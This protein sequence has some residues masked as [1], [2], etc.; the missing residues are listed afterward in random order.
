MWA[1][2]LSV[3]FSMEIRGRI[4]LKTFLLYGNTWPDT[5]QRAFLCADTWAMR[6]MWRTWSTRQGTR[7]A[8]TDGVQG[9]AGA[10]TGCWVTGC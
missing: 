6:G 8:V 10:G 3:R 2:R 7:T 9:H 4:R 5:A 1:M